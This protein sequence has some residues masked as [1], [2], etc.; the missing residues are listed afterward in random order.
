MERTIV[1]LDIGTT[2]ICTLVAQI[3]DNN[4]LRVVGVGV[5]PALGIRKGVIT[6][7]EE[8][9]KAIGAAL[10]KAERVA[11]CTISDAYVGVGGNHI[12]SQNSKGF[13]AIGRGDRPVERDDIDRAIEAALAVAVPHNRR[14]IHTIPRQFAI[15][16]QDGIKNPIGLLGYRLEVEAHLVTGAASSIQNLVRCVE[17]NRI[18]IADLV[19]QPLAS[20]EA[21]LTEDEKNMGVALVDMG[22]GTTDLAIYMDGSISHTMVIGV[23]G[24]HITNDIAVG[25]RTPFSSAEDVKIRYGH[26]LP[27]QVES[28][29]RLEIATFGDKSLTTVSRQDV[30]KIVSNRC[31]EMLELIGME[32]KRAGFDG[33]LPAGVVLTGGSASLTGIRELAAS[34]LGL[35]ARVGLPRRLHGLV[36]TISSPAYATGVGLLLWG[37]RAEVT[38][39]DGT[40]RPTGY[41]GLVERVK[42][43]L[44][45]LLPRA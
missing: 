27:Q 31:D 2:K 33:L 28:D 45:A 35:P 5:V 16:G 19:L 18:G 32:I 24:N 26:A 36:E 17:A 29:D 23:G 21:V 11:G 20:A 38:A 30:C 37:M 10:Q 42:D 15:D 39:P 34:K 14:I 25:L 7:V 8:A 40:E 12:A 13:A 44:K 9:A 1:G 22:G 6:D 4:A 3:A 43:W 41:N